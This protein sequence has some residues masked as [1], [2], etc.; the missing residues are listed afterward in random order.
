MTDKDGKGGASWQPAPLA[1]KP[2]RFSGP[3]LL[4]V[5]SLSYLFWGFTMKFYL[6]QVLLEM[7][8]LMAFPGNLLLQRAHCHS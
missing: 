6:G 1:R 8:R 2:H 4:P 3:S 5:M 7:R